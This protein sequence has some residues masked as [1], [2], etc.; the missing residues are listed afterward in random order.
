MLRGES[1]MSYKKGVHKSLPIITGPYSGELIEK[2]FENK[3][4]VEERK[5]AL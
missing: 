3:P 5:K 1:H 4:P 2:L